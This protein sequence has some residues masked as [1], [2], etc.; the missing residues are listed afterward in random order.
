MAPAPPPTQ[1]TCGWRRSAG[2]RRSGATAAIDEAE[3]AHCGAAPGV[4]P[5]GQRADRG[6][7]FAS[8]T[9]SA[10]LRRT[11][12]NS[13]TAENEMKFE[14]LQRIEGNFTYDAA[15]RIVSFAV[16][17]NMKIRGHALV[18]HSQNP[19]WLFSNGASR[20]SISRCTSPA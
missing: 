11:H 17:N 9:Q 7:S 15:D 13:V 19:S 12:F 10:A 1:G 6:W 14:S 2:R 3:L 20:S 5:W 4:P 18:W 16:A 8:A